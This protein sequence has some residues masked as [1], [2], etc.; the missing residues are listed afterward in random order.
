MRD[1]RGDGPEGGNGRGAEDAWQGWKPFAV[2]F[3]ALVLVVFVW[4]IVQLVRALAFEEGVERAAIVAMLL[5]IAVT[6]GTVVLVGG[7]LA[8]AIRREGI[9]EP[10]AGEGDGDTP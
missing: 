8:A 3:G 1:T 2:G 4:E 6:L 7:G 5:M 10:G 9:A